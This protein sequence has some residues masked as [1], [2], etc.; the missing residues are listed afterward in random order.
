M[1][2]IFLL[3]LLFVPFATFAQKTRPAWSKTVEDY[4]NL[5]HEMEEDPFKCDDTP[6]S[7]AAR[8]RA[9]VVKDIKNGYLRAKTTMG[10]I[11]VAVFKDVATETEY[12]LYQLDGGPHNMCTTDLRVMV[13]KN[14][15]WTE[16]PQVLPQ[17]KISDAAA[18][19]PIRANIDTYLVYKLPQKGTI[20]N[21]SW[22]G[23]GKRVFALRWEK[24]KFVFVP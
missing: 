4:Y 14:G 12:V 22:K 18:K 16:K 21:A 13:Y 8:T 24:G 17:N 20:I 7:A 15:K 9:V 3:A 6:S 1:R 2:K 5:F 23:N 11:E 19:Q 10:I